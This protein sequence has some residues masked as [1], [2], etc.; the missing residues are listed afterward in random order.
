MKNRKKI[1]FYTIVILFP[2]FMLAI[3]ELTLRVFS[4]GDDLSLFVSSPDPR[5]YEI[6]RHVGERFFSKSEITVPTPLSQYFLKEKPENG[7]RI[8]VL[9][10]STVEGFPYDA[11]LTFTKILRKRLQD[12]FPDRA[13]EVVN[14]GMTAIDSYTLLDFAGEVLQQKPDAVLMYTGHNEYY[15]ALGVGS[16]ENGSI[17][18]WMKRLELILVHF[19]TYQLLEQ[20]IAG[21]LGIIHPVTYDESRATLM[22]RMVGRDL[23]PYGSKMYWG[24]IGQFSDN[25][26]KLI[27]RLKDANVSV[28]ISD[29]VCNVGDQPPFRSLR[30]GRYP[31][32]DSVYSDAARL[33]A[34]QDFAEARQEFIEA[35]D[36]D[37]IRFRGPEDM[38]RVIARLSDSLGV[39][40]T[41][42]KTLFENRSPNGIV[43][44]NLMTDHLHPNIDGYFLMAEGF[45][46]ALREHSMVE[47]NWN[48]SRMKPWTWYRNNWGFTE[49]DS[50]IAV[51]RIKHLKAGWPFQPET[52]VNN[53]RNT[54]TPHGMVDSLAFMTIQYVDVSPS[55]VH[56]KLASYYESA[57]DFEH[58]SKE[59]LAL[60]NLSPLDVS[61][62]YYAADLAVRARD[63]SDAI[64]YLRESPGSDT[65]SYAQ[66][67]LASFYYS[68]K[69]NQEALS[70]IDKLESL[71]LDNSV[72]F[73]VQKLKYK[74][75]KD[76]GLVSEAE[77]TLAVIKNMDPT[78]TESNKAGNVIILMPDKIKPYIDKA[79]AMLKVGQVSEALDILKEA[80]NIREVPY[81]DLLIGKILFAQKNIEALPYLEKACVELKDDPS[82]IYRLC[83]LYM[84]KRDMAKAKSTMNDFA[85]LQGEN[86][87]QYKQLKTIFGKTFLGKN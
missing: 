18:K 43:G 54:Y 63:T 14:L 16:M 20:G 71:H 78:F 51:V 60:A 1:F 73:R 84:I 72:M 52:A 65:S 29:L 58:A 75:Q 38:N 37:A 68:Q 7:Y 53:F 81:T 4:Y 87:P 67:T 61:S 3:L 41:S 57:G 21:I 28:I 35:K 45:L 9:G 77:T 10:E 49:L 48:S 82:L 26:G 46:D 42:L 70:C 5:Y 64:R 31:S 13:I 32:A 34:R 36:L 56:K 23:I 17:P 83:V 55:M 76:S 25:M 79:D 85:K 27:V 80:N 59:Y 11:N 22:E 12:I 30:F 39:Y 2:F 74:V 62:Y 86:D 15:G 8:F 69:N 6:N 40:R 24:G 66:Y 47:D 19:R 44:D 50:M 33:R